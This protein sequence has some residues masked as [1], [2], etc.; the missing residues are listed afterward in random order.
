M[1]Q[2]VT[3]Q[4]ARKHRA[5]EAAADSHKPIFRSQAVKLLLSEWDRPAQARPMIEAA[6][7]V[8]D[9]RGSFAA[10]QRC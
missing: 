10:P 8:V 4:V 7:V 5:P 1:V 2:A 6:A 3:A 9:L